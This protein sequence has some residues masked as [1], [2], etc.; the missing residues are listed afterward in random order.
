MWLNV[1]RVPGPG[2]DAHWVVRLLSMDCVR[3][4]I[5][6]SSSTGVAE[7]RVFG[8]QWSG[9]CSPAQHSIAWREGTLGGVVCGHSS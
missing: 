5:F 4:T 6:N 1:G 7:T 8:V 9:T 3:K 2:E